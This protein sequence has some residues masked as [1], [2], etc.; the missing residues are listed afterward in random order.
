M[1]NS[2]AAQRCQRRRSALN[3]NSTVSAMSPSRRTSAVPSAEVVIDRSQQPTPSKDSSR[4]RKLFN[5]A[6]LAS[7][8]ELWSGSWKKLPISVLV[9]APVLLM[10]YSLVK[11]TNAY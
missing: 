8:G 9:L 3:A 1:G 10:Y 2:Q 5:L 11:I 7:A 4:E 6:C